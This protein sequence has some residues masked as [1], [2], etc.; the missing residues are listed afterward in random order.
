MKFTIVGRFDKLLEENKLH[1]D[2]LKSDLV[3]AIFALH[4]VLKTQ[5]QETRNFFIH[6]CWS[7][8]RSRDELPADDCFQQLRRQA[9]K[10]E[11]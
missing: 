1:Y 4:E 3:N 9:T 6:F 8:G 7:R 5:T 10:E 2:N 11:R